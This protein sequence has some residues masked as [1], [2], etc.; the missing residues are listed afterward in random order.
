MKKATIAQLSQAVAPLL[1]VALLALPAATS[2][3]ASAKATKAA[4]GAVLTPDWRAMTLADFKRTDQFGIRKESDGMVS[5]T[6]DFDGDGTVDSAH[7]AQST[8]G[9]TFGVVIILDA[10]PA[11]TVIPYYTTASYDEIAS[12]GIALAE[13]GEYQT[14]CGKGYWTCAA[15]EPAKVT[16]T[17][18]GIAFFTIESSSSVLMWDKAKKEFTMVPLDD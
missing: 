10:K 2:A 13:P 9:K 3:A 15:G 18:P 16:L 8:D 5:A 17:S 7:L 14:A 12:Q 6:G 4:S 1:A 11:K